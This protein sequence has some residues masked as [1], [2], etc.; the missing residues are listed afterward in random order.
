MLTIDGSQGEGGGQMLREIVRMR[1]ANSRPMCKS[2]FA[3]TALIHTTWSQL[4]RAAGLACVL[5]Q[6]AKPALDQSSRIV[7]NPE[8]GMR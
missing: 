3:M 5:R 1:L 7:G 6:Y 8:I 4:E 2:S